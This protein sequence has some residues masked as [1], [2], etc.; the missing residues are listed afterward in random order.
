MAWTQNDTTA[1]DAEGA[2]SM[3][4]VVAERIR[5]NLI[6]HTSTRLR[7]ASAVWPSG[8]IDFD[9]GTTD[10]IDYEITRYP[11]DTS[12]TP[13]T[14]G[15]G[16][17]ASSPESIGLQISTLPNDPVKIELPFA[18]SSYATHVKIRITATCRSHGTGGGVQ[19]YSSQDEEYI[20]PYSIYGGEVELVKQDS[21]DPDYSGI[22][23]A[24]GDVAASGNFSY[25]EMTIPILGVRGRALES[26]RSNDIRLFVR[27]YLD[28]S[29]TG[30]TTPLGNDVGGRV[31]IPAEEYYF[32]TG[33]ST[34][35][36]GPMHIMA[37]N[38]ANRV[39]SYG[40]NIITE[41]ASKSGENFLAQF[42]RRFDSLETS[43]P[44]LIHLPRLVLAALTIEEV[45]IDS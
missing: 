44:R 45:R 38:T 7:K 41:P 23:I 32:A 34:I 5:A 25:Y 19:V 37:L 28:T 39:M 31:E 43:E 1:F 12:T 30:P 11:E 6:E 27:S 21:A 14:I 33:Q 16:S 26:G 13:N 2:V 22:D 20:E 24:T 42:D 29:A 35:M 15:T 18:F 17:L 10:P 36:P 8:V 40:E 9:G 4:Q 3:S